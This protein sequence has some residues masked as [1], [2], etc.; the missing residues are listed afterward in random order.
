MAPRPCIS[1]NTLIPSGSRCEDCRLLKVR[2][3]ERHRP[4]RHVRGYGNEWAR[5]SK[6]LR[7]AQPWCSNCGSTANLSVD[8]VKPGSMEHG[9]RVLCRRCHARIGARRVGASGI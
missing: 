2:Q 3:R 5:T 6:A 4:S 7:E 1:C 9:L 8:H